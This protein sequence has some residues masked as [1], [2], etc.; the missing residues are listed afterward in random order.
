MVSYKK[1]LRT[2]IVTHLVDIVSQH[3]RDRDQLCRRRGRNSQEEYHKQRRGAGLPKDGGGGGSK[4][5]SG[6]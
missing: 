1:A 4:L 2:N 5:A 3:R 6:M